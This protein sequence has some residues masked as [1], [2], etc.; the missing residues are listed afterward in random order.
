MSTGKG[1]PSLSPFRPVAQCWIPGLQKTSRLWSPAGPAVPGVAALHPLPCALGKGG[2]PL[3]EQKPPGR[4]REWTPGLSLPSPWQLPL[5]QQPSLKIQPKSN[6]N[7]LWKPSPG[8]AHGRC[9]VRL[10]A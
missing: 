5:E 1:I 10:A 4:D 2:D 3:Q 9:L 7:K 6:F 8:N